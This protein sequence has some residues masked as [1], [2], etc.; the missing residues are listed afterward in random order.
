MNEKNEKIY[1]AL[2]DAFELYLKEKLEKNPDLLKDADPDTR[3]SVGQSRGDYDSL[4]INGSYTGGGVVSFDLKFEF[5]M[6]EEAL[7]YHPDL[8]RVARMRTKK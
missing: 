8:L 7:K 6:C 3:A 1:R 2:V 5:A 4:C